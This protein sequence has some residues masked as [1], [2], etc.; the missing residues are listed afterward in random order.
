MASSTVPGVNGD[1]AA[2]SVKTSLPSSTR[3]LPPFEAWFP[4]LLSRLASVLVAPEVS[5]ALYEA[6]PDL[7]SIVIKTVPEF[8]RITQNDERV[9]AHHTFSALLALLGLPEFQ[10][11]GQDKNILLWA[12]LLHDVSKEVP[13]CHGKKQRDPAHPFRCAGQCARIFKRL[14]LCLDGVDEASVEAWATAAS[15]AVV[16]HPDGGYGHVHDNSKVAELC[17][18]LRKLFCPSSAVF[19][20]LWV[21]MMHQSLPGVSAWPP[22]AP[23][24]AAQTQQTCSPRLVSLLLPTML[25]DSSSY[26]LGFASATKDRLVFESDIRKNL[27]EVQRLLE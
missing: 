26:Q 24:S 7:A 23:L 1:G 4:G 17:Q 15:S 6:L 21:I 19:E 5:G 10:A 2:A 27:A 13:T 14:D 20:V 11:A 16:P 12:I 22:A 25:A 18:G 3:E 9:V 8:E